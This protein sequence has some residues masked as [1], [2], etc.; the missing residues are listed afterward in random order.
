MKRIFLHL[1]LVAAPFAPDVFAQSDNVLIDPVAGVAVSKRDVAHYF[2]SYGPGKTAAAM[3]VSPNIELAIERHYVA[4]ALSKRAEQQAL[5][6]DDAL[7]WIGEQAINRELMQQYLVWQI[8]QDTEN[9]DWTELAREYYLVNK[10]SFKSEVEVHTRHLL[11]S[12][13]DRRLYD[14][15]LIAEDLRERV[16]AGEDFEALV[17]AHSEGPSAAQGGS[18]GYTQR[19]TLLPEFERAAF[20][21]EVGEISDLIV[22]QHGVHLIQLV[23]RKE[24]EQL[25]F[26]AVQSDLVAKIQSEHK[27]NLREALILTEKHAAGADGV[28]V[29]REWIELVR[30]AQTRDEALGDMSD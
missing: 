30:N 6:S 15:V 22:T 7:R 25:D 10:A 28:A 19:G 23:D 3:S 5:L 24:P 16:T 9:A 11:I 27:Q 14:A 18:L 29:D 20:S 13:A 17:K 26:D 8:E 2:S 1:L 21:L 4:S 12:T